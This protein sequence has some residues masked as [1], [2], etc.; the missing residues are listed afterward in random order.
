MVITQ[1]GPCEEEGGSGRAMQGGTLGSTCRGLHP[2]PVMFPCLLE[3]QPGTRYLLL[4]SLTAHQDRA[5]EQ[6]PSQ[7]VGTIWGHQVHRLQYTAPP[8]STMPAG[9]T[10]AEGGPRPELFSLVPGKDKS[11]WF[12]WHLQ[13]TYFFWLCSVR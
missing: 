2:L 3:L 1:Q 8:L 6:Q 10:K 13:F 11:S 7:Q 12:V 9:T 5:G 4:L